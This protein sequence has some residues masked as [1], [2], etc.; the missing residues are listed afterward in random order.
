MADA[1]QETALVPFQ[2]QHMM[3][4]EPRNFDDAWQLCEIGVKS[5]LLPKAV[6]K[7]E[8]AV[9]I[10][11]R[12]REMGLTFMQ[13]FA[14]IN[15]IEGKTSLTAELIVARVKQHRSVCKYFRFVSG[16]EKQATF[17]T[18]RVDEPEPTPFTFTWEDAVKLKLSDKDNYKKQ[19]KTMLRWRCATTLARLVYPELTLGLYSPDEA[20]DIAQGNEAAVTAAPSVPAKP[21]LDAEIVGASPTA[22]AVDKTATAPV[23]KAAT[24][25]D[26]QKAVR[27]IAVCTSEATTPEQL[28][29][30]LAQLKG[31][32]QEGGAMPKGAHR[33]RVLAAY[34]AANEQLTAAIRA[35]KDGAANG[36]QAND[37]TGP[38]AHVDGD[39]VVC[40]REGR[41]FGARGYRCAK[42]EQDAP[43]V[44]REP[45]VD[46]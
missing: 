6:Q 5:G 3:A 4:L 18:W 36:Q 14:S 12:G 32:R 34:N 9:M 38:C 40:N 25:T 8:Q 39:G 44:E 22:A 16:D 33:D 24:E 45:G 41:H 31:V 17:E 11:L 29:K 42:H 30:K 1:T 7:T 19:P 20:E 28:N 10:Y 26:E 21:V 35:L 2:Q 13:S 27:L 37:N 43:Q 46:G 23:G 15:V